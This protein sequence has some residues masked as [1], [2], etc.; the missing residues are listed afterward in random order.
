MFKWAVWMELLPAAVYQAMATVPGLRT[1]RTEAPEPEPIGPV[2]DATVKDT[3]P[4]LSP[5]VAD[6]V[7][8]QQATGCRPAEVCRIRPIDLDTSGPTWVYRP[9]QHK[10]AWHGHKRIIF[11]GPRGQGVLRP[12]LLRPAESFCFSP[13]DGERKTPAPSCTRIAQLHCRAGIDLAR[14][15]S[16]VPEGT[17][18]V[19]RSR[20]YHG[21]VR[22]AVLKA[23]KTTKEQRPS[24]CAGGT[25]TNCGI[26]SLPRSESISA[27]RPYRRSWATRTWWSVRSTRKRISP[28]R[29]GHAEDRLNILDN[30]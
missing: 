20:S 21:A 3:L 4:Y 6:M 14:I 12:Y 27:W 16:G 24:R 9:A 29:G 18:R 8:F 17:G 2:D 26:R 10:T 11:I 22:R 28:C 15:R 13:M 23:N 7:R 30:G 25:R 5:I 1:G 19:L